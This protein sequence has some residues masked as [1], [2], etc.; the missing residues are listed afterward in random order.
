[1]NDPGRIVILGAGPA[2]LAAG[3]R[4]HELGFKDFVIL[5]AA[6][7]PGGLARSVVDRRGFTWDIGGHVHFSHYATYDGLLRRALGDRW[8]EHGRNSW[9]WVRGRFVPYPL[10]NHISYLDEG[11]QRQ[12]LAGLEEA[13]RRRPKAVSYTHLTLPTN[14]EV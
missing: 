2:G 5:E 12:C 3:T 4:L 8:L 14:R 1:M 10:Q 6:E 13:R 11:D 9:I 7:V